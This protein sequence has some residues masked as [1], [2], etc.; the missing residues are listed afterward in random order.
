M[1]MRMIEIARYLR[2]AQVSETW[3]EHDCMRDECDGCRLFL[4]GVTHR[5]EA[6]VSGAVCADSVNTLLPLAVWVALGVTVA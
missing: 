1:L 6:C 2:H 4:Q 5:T 3:G